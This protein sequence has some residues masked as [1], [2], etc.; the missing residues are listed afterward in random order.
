MRAARQTTLARHESPEVSRRKGLRSGSLT[1]CAGAAVTLGG[2]MTMVGRIG[3][4]APA[5]E[6][7][8]PVTLVLPQGDGSLVRRT[9]GPG[10]TRTVNC[11]AKGATG[12]TFTPQPWFPTGRPDRTG[13][14][15]RPKPEAKSTTWASGYT[16]SGSGTATANSTPQGRTR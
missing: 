3:K 11:L 2:A 5:K 10:G 4:C 9:D 14:G 16:P 8:S 7:L 12:P 13:R 6:A 15:T 1:S